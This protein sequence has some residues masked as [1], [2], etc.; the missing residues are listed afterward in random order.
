MYMPPKAWKTDIQKLRMHITHI[1][2]V[3]K[4]HIRH[5]ERQREIT[6][7]NRRRQEKRKNAPTQAKAGT[8][9]QTAKTNI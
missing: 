1:E 7:T 6:E 9:V 4:A 5:E 2:H 3:E 8:I